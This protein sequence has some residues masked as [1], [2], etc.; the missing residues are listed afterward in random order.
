MNALMQYIRMVTDSVSLDTRLR[1]LLQVRREVDS[2]IYQVKTEQQWLEMADL[3]T[4]M[5]SAEDAVPGNQD[6]TPDELALALDS[7]HKD[8][9]RRRTARVKLGFPATNLPK[10]FTGNAG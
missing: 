2:L 9:E 7:I 5:K 8:R 6:F 3:R 10:R 4:A 1:N